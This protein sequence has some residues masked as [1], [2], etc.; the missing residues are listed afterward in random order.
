MKIS[1]VQSIGGF[2]GG[3]KASLVQVFL[4]GRTHRMVQSLIL[5]RYAV[6]KAALYVRIPSSIQVTALAD[7]L[8]W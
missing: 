6:S 5:G 7:N 4:N 1:V 8:Q 2:W 3:F